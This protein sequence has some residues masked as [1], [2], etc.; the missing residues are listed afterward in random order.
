MNVQGL[1]KAVNAAYDAYERAE[2]ET[3]SARVAAKAANLR[4]RGCASVAASRHA[5]YARALDRLQSAEAAPPATTDPAT[6]A[7]DAGF[8]EAGV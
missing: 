3:V 6:V 7:D 1:R 4:L 5:E 2:R 8:S